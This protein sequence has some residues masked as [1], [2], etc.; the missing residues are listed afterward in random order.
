MLPAPRLEVCRSVKLL[1]RHAFVHQDRRCGRG[2]TATLPAPPF[3]LVFL[4]FAGLLQ[5]QL[6]L[7]PALRKRPGLRDAAWSLPHSTG[8]L[9][10]AVEMQ[11]LRKE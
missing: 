1:T 8:H 3:R 2:G 5:Q 4:R 10:M 7:E 11:L 6:L 9:D